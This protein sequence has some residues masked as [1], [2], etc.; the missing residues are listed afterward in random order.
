[1]SGKKVPAWLLKELSERTF[2]IWT[3]DFASR[4]GTFSQVVVAAIALT[5]A[6]VAL[7]TFAHSRKTY[8]YRIVADLL[9]EYREV[10][11]GNAIA[12]LWER[13]RSKYGKNE[14]APVEG[15][16]KEYTDGHTDLQSFHSRRRMVSHY[17]MQVAA[18]I[19]QGIVPADLFYANWT[20]TDLAIIDKILIPINL[21][22]L[23][24]TIGEQPSTRETMPWR[25]ARLLA[26]YRNARDE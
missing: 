23:P 14:D 4:I 6:I 15:Y 7:V 26:L 8:K 11:M 22:A 17:Y 12:F 16:V 19:D 9:K 24:K 2:N 5:T 3:K 21:R 10:V 18:L 20:K 13:F 1:M 25:D